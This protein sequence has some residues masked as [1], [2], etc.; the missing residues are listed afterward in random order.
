MSFF[1]NRSRHDCRLIPTN[2]C[3]IHVPYSRSLFF[4]WPTY[5]TVS[6]LNFSL[7]TYITC[8]RKALIRLLSF[9]LG[10]FFTFSGAKDRR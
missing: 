2:A 7:L 6:Y 1:L 4:F 10:R 8:T 5:N 9:S 3:M